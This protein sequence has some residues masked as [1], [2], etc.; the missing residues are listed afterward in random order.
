MMISEMNQE[1]KMLMIR[2]TTSE[3]THL[4]L[5]L[6]LFNISDNLIQI[7]TT[8][9]HERSSSNIRFGLRVATIS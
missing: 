1:M 5:E 7:F 2:G 6:P 4:F 8:Y 9:L 3:C